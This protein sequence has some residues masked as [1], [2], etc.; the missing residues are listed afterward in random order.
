MNIRRCWAALV[1][2]MLAACAGQGTNDVPGGNPIGQGKDSGGDDGA[3]ANDSGGTGDGGGDSASDDGG[4]DAAPVDG[5]IPIETGGGDANAC[6]GLVTQ[7]SPA[8]NTCL[9]ATCCPSVMACVND[10]NCANYD[11]CMYNCHDACD[12]QCTQMF[13]QGSAESKAFQQCQVQCSGSCP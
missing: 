5:A 13:P 8:C 10:P 2:A 6:Q 12:Q 9:E 3:S 1:G 4:A 11:M 7:Y